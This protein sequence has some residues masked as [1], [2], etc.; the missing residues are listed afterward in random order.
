M[1]AKLSSWIAILAVALCSTALRADDRQK[2]DIITLYN[3]DRITGEIKALDGG[4]LQ[5]STDALDTVEIEWPEIAGVQSGYHYEVR[6]SDGNRL[7]G[8]FKDKAKPGQLVLVDIYGRH[9]VELLQ[10]VEIRPIEERVIDRIDIYLST[11]FSYT[12]ASSV[13]QASLN[14]NIGYENE[15]STNNFT[16]RTDITRTNDDD[17]SSTDVN[18]TRNTWT[19]DR[20]SVFRAIFASYES[21]DE[22]DLTRRL[23]AGAGLGRYFVDTH[24][25]TLSGTA[26]LQVISEDNKGDNV[27]QQ[28]ELFFNTHYAA[29]K[30]TTP[31][32][33]IVLDFD[34]YPSVTE[35]GRVRTSSNLRLRWELVKDL[36]WDVTAWANTDNDSG[37]GSSSD[38]AIT[39]GLGWNN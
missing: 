35:F 20:S 24:R 17:T 33:D 18:F 28:L 3:G 26:G 21:N 25:N 14:T 38:Y 12:K 23:S 32:M 19:R 4:Q 34:L 37:T 30:F 6:L 8:S 9:E 1:L 11:T 7:Y 15:K 31:E 10:V 13:G 29:W 22:L 27:D 16:A 5:L 2:I 39:T 36:Y